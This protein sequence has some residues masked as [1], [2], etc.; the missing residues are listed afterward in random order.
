M[1]TTMTNTDFKTLMGSVNSALIVV[2]TSAENVQAGCLVGYHSQSSI[3]PE[4]YCFWLSKANHT[5][6]VGL[7]APYFGVHFLTDKDLEIAQRFSTQS[8][9]Y[10]DKFAGLQMDSEPHDIPLLADCPNR[11]VLERL[12][13]VDDGGDHV[14]VTATVVSANSAGK[15]TPLRITDLGYT[16][17]AHGS[18]E[19]IIR[20]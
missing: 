3:S 15:F 2:T 10:T 5:Y 19:R 17:P 20:P 1:M 12:A 14:C 18:D 9:Q 13:V 6:R 4:H 16:V 7:L 8:G 11:M